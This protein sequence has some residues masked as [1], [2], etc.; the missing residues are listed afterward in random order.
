MDNP[1]SPL[2]ALGSMVR[3]TTTVAGMAAGSEGIFLHTVGTDHAV[4][5]FWD[6]GP[7]HVPL[8]ALEPVD[9]RPFI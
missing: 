5:S 6:G 3:V 2:F 7:L 1:Q 9:P 8:T 4:V